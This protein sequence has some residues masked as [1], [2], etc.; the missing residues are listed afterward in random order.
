[1]EQKIITY[2]DC[3]VDV[4]ANTRWTKWIAQQVKN[5]RLANGI[6][7][8]GAIGGFAGG[9]TIPPFM[10]AKIVQ[11]HLKRYQGISCDLEKVLTE[12]LTSYQTVACTD[13]V[14]S[15]TMYGERLYRLDTLGYDLVGMNVNDMVVGGAIPAGFLDYI[16]CHHIEVGGKFWYQPFIEGLIKACR[17][18][19]IELLGGETAEIGDSYT[20]FGSDLTGT[21]IGYIMNSDIPLKETVKA[22]DVILAMR[23]SGIHSNGYSRIRKLVD[24]NNID[25]LQEFLTGHNLNVGQQVQGN[26]T[27]ADALLEP[28][29]LY[30]NQALSANATRKVKAMAHI[31]GGGLSENILRSLPEGFGIEL[32]IEKYPTLPIFDWIKEKGADPADMLKTFNMGFGYVFVADKNDKAEIEAAAGELLYEIGRVA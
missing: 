6:N 22:G 5:D 19:N 20:E 30:V 28:T 26:Y 21:A 23:S 25:I 32:E 15:K 12:V 24:A 3:G 10:V 8:V 1:M 17:S 13:G 14:G 11:F 16:G 9:M 7:H 4:D 2:K 18:V 27:L 29:R 31:T